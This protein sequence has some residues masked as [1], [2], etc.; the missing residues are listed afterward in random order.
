M[1]TTARLAD[2]NARA[3]A[4]YRAAWPGSPAEA[5]ARS[6]GLSDRAAAH[7]G[8]GYAPPRNALLRRLAAEGVPEAVLVEAGL[9]RA[10]ERGTGDVFRDRLVMPIPAE[11]GTVLGFGSRR[12]RDD[13]PAVPKY[14]NSPETPLY[15]KGSVLY[16]LPNLPAAA[17]AREAVVVEGN[18]DMLSLWDAGV[19]NAVA[20]C[21]TAVTADHLALLAARGASVT[22]VLDS[23]AAGVR[24]TRKALLLPGTGGLDVSVVAIPD[25]P[26]GAK[27]DPDALLREGGLPAW[28]EALARR[29]SRWEH[30]W[31]GTAA[32][33]E[34]AALAGDLEAQTAWAAAWGSSVSGV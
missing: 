3:A 17:A 30:L 19:A 1:L 27:R 25:G 11:D 8:L 12:L 9:A 14:L 20:T 31:A 13:D 34:A 18:L 6:R 23:D 26:D 7:W 15:R 32:E 10:G 16:G 4:L 2:L 28:R 21:G 22:L 24:A 33:H 29:T 5:Y